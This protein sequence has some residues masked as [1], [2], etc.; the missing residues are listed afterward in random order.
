M[1]LIRSG[2][3]II[4]VADAIGVA[5]QTL[6]ALRKADPDFAREWGEAADIGDL[7]QL[8]E[9]V[10]E[11]DF[12][13]RLGWLEPKFYEGRVCGF[14][15]KYSDGLLLARMKALAPEKY[16]DKAKVDAT[17]NSPQGLVLEFV[18]ADATDTDTQAL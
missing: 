6:Y 11:A 7:I 4:D 9:C 17:L 18:S 5:R 10:K 2:E 14:I 1:E 12:R 16:G 8:S 13:G 3:Q 15:R